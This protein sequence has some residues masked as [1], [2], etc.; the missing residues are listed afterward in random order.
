M[1]PFVTTVILLL[2]LCLTCL[3]LRFAVA[4]EGDAPVL[5]LI[6]DLTP[7]QDASYSYRAEN[8]RRTVA[9][10]LYGF[11]GDTPAVA[12]TPNIL[13]DRKALAGFFK[14]HWDDVKRDYLGQ[15]AAQPIKLLAGEDSFMSKSL[16]R[17]LDIDPAKMVGV[18]LPLGSLGPVGSVGAWTI[19]GGYSWDEENPALMLRTNEGFMVGVGYDTPQLGMQ[20]S[21]L[22]SG[23]E[24]M[25]LEIGGDDIRYDSV[26]LGFS[27]RVN[28]RMGVT[29]TAQYRN[30]DDPLTTGRNQ[31]VFTVGTKWQF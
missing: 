23:Q 12:A 30:D 10:M 18:T 17:G 15:N 5:R 22:T 14:Q 20:I 7:Q 26:L 11:T 3:T 8:D 25:G 31:G 9:V 1:R 6:T 27:W 13:K 4:D 28:A 16:N 19:G 21:Y 2:A 29:A 24:V